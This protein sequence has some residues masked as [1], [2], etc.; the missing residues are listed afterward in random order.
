MNSFYKKFSSILLVDLHIIDYR[1]T[2]RFFILL[3]F[4]IIYFYF[5]LE[6]AYMDPMIKVV[7]TCGPPETAETIVGIKGHFYT[8]KAIFIKEGVVIP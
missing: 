8:H 2:T 5:N 1:G 7:S 3:V 4:S 6:V